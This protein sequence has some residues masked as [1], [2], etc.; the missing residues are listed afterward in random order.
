MANKTNYKQPKMGILIVV[1][2]QRQTS[3]L[4]IY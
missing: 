2:L 4:H 3:C 1:I